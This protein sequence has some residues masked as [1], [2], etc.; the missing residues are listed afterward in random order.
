MTVKIAGKNG[1]DKNISASFF[2]VESLLS[3][4][5][6]GCKPQTGATGK[7]LSLLPELSPSLQLPD[8]KLG[9]ICLAVKTHTFSFIA[10]KSNVWNI[11]TWE[12]LYWRRALVWLSP[13]FWLTGVICEAL[14][15]FVLTS[16]AWRF[17]S[18]QVILCQHYVKFLVSTT[19]YLKNSS[20]W[21][22][23]PLWISLNLWP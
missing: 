16:E 20:V 10:M 4:G 2:H 23:I 3:C 8:P 14:I 17:K 13:T 21:N 9:F 6:C 22:L 11:S 18:L 1:G 15:K 19:V 7:P 12:L 5:V